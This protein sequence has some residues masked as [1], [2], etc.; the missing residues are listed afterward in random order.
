MKI[1]ISN[2]FASIEKIPLCCFD[3]WHFD[4]FFLF[5]S[6]HWFIFYPFWVGQKWSCP[7][8]GPGMPFWENI[9]IRGLLLSSG[10]LGKTLA[11][12][13][14]SE[15]LTNRKRT[16]HFWAALHFYSIANFVAS[17][18]KWLQMI[19]NDYKWQSMFVIN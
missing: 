8:G 17:W 11:L 7:K 19:L 16:V 15:V 1:A 18:L 3:V 9:W 2:F 6:F 14:T 10:F 12:S 13:P 4:I 5:P